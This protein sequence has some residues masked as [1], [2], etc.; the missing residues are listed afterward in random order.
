MTRLPVRLL[1][2]LIATA[3][4]L[5]AAIAAPAEAD[6][7]HS[8]RFPSVIELP[9]GFAPEGIAIDTKKAYTGSLL[10]GQ[11][12]VI[13]LK[14]GRTTEFAPSPGPGKIA[15]GLDVDRRD[16]LWVAGGG[17]AFFPGVSAG[18]R[19]Y[20]TDNGELLADIELPDAGFV[21]DVI[22]TR[23]A[24]WLTDTFLPVVYRVPIAR[25]GT[26]GEPE[27]VALGGD[28]Q[29]SDGLNANGIVAARNGRAL[30]IAQ[31]NAPDGAGAALY[32]M[33]A[34]LD[35][36]ELTAS[37]IDL[38]AEL[39]G[40]DGLV[41]VGRTLYSVGDPAGVAKIRLNRTLTTGRV[42]DTLAVPDVVSP[43]TAAVFGHRLYVVDANFP[44]LGD[45]TSEHTLTA[46]RR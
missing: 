22:V 25:D 35:A 6:R 38:D 40:A 17:S 31:V 27:T 33:P 42:V 2:T 8:D 7:R 12:E 26:I 20:D 19:V 30:I 46:I 4:V 18:Y 32:S 23:R 37:R 36:A 28:W 24:A 10:T 45:P 5:T 15:V 16:R 29:Q 39:A 9:D 14:S 1:A 43:T 3:A 44:A 11:I 21:N 34:D 41:L 13:D